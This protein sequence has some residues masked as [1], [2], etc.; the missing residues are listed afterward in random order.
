MDKKIPK[1]IGPIDHPVL[2]VGEKI[3]RQRN[4]CTEKQY[5]LVG[6]RTGDFVTEAIGDKTNI[7]L[8]NLIN[9]NLEGDIRKVDKKIINEGMIDLTLL[10]FTW[11]P[12]KIITLGNFVQDHLYKIIPVNDLQFKVI[13]FP[14]PSWINRFR[15]SQ[16][17]EY[18]NQLK[19]H[20]T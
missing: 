9:H 18:I 11:Y 10:I 16:R 13:A 20:I 4:D 2:I 19:N 1:L 5:A 3:G 8:T 15:S 12:R 14:H 7:I 6:N 17:S